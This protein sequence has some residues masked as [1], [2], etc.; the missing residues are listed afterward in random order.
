MLVSPTDDRAD[1]RG[2]PLAA[3]R[4]AAHG[5]PH[6]VHPDRAVQFALLL[7]RHAVLVRP[8]EAPIDRFTSRGGRAKPNAKRMSYRGR[9]TPSERFGEARKTTGRT[10]VTTVIET[11]GSL[12]ISPYLKIPQLILSVDVKCPSSKMQSHNRWTNLPKLRSRDV[13]KF[14]IADRKDYLYARRVVRRYRGPASL[15]F[16]RSGV[17]TR[18]GWRT[19]SSVTI[20]T[21]AS[22]SRNTRSSGVTCP[23][24]EAPPRTRR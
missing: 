11:G 20:W 10:G 18:A 14:V 6:H 21:S 1:H 16:S 13:L 22:C 3:G 7:V 19:G 23:A 9:A 24:A 4:R 15:V 12:E 5:A 17:P 8:R 2:F